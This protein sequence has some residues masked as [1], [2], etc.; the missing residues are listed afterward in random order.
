MVSIFIDY[1]ESIIEVFMDD[2]SV[3]GNSFDTCLANLT[4]VLKKMHGHQLG[5]EL[6]KMSFHGRTR[7]CAKTYRI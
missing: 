5:V 4:L 3:Y 7:N 2:F 6:G 1:I